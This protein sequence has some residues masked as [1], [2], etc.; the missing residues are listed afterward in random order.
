MD[1]LSEPINFITAIVYARK[2]EQPKVV[3]KSK[4]H[5]GCKSKVERGYIIIEKRWEKKD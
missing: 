1:S 4:S 2:I 5:R 3:K